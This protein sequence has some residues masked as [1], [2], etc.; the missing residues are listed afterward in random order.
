[1]RRAL[2]AILLVLPAVATDV[3]AQGAPRVITSDDLPAFAKLGMTATFV[4]ERQ[5]VFAL[6]IGGEP[7][8]AEPNA[9]MQASLFLM[10]ATRSLVVD[11]GYEEWMVMPGG[12]NRAQV[13]LLHPGEDAATVLGPPFGQSPRLSVRDGRM[14]E[15]CSR[16]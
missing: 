9:P 3:A 1:M 11:A 2:L 16:K 15:A 13:G 5:R 8:R 7:N 10:C 4:P 12:P 6:A 14:A